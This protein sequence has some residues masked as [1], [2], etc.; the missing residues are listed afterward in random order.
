MITRLWN[1]ITDGLNWFGAWLPQLGLRLILA[2]EYGEAGLIKLRGDNWFDN[3]KD[4]FPFPFNTIP[5]DI[6]WQ[7]ATWAEIL[8]AGALVL[9]LFT[10]FASLTLIILTVVATI[11]VHMPEQWG[12]LGELWQGYRVSSSEFGN[13][14]LP[15]LFMLMLLPLL[16]TGAGKLSID[17]LVKK[18]SDR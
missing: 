7:I 15:L 10:R 13:F 1:S 16:C 4:A 3:I 8:G 5:T 12:S 18:I 2:W 11:A 6:S 9:G 17:H 14:K